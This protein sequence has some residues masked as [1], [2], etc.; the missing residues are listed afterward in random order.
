MNFADA[1]K[2]PSIPEVHWGVIKKERELV[3]QGRYREVAPYRSIIDCMAELK[4]GPGTS[5]LEIGAATGFYDRVLK[6]AG[7]SF[8]YTALDY[9]C[10]FKDFAAV[11]HPDIPFLLGD[12]VNLENIATN[13]YAIVISG[14]CILHIPEWKMAM[15]ETVRV[16]KDYIIWHRTPLVDGPTR[17]FTKEAYG[18]QC[19]ET[20]FNRK[21]FYT[22]IADLGL[23]VLKEVEVFKNPEYSHVSIVCEK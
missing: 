8:R 14:C 7:Y 21:E 23:T 5:V 1:W 13:S 18:V 9:S 17:T 10:A 12:A 16:A 19:S 11:V 6:S 20:W 2:N 22:I 3:A 15:R 4:M